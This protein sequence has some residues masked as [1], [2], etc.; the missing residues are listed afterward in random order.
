MVSASTRAQTSKNVVPNGS[1]RFRTDNASGTHRIV[2]K[3]CFKT[4]LDEYTGLVI[5]ERPNIEKRSTK[6][7]AWRQELSGTTN[8]VV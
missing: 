3:G 8:I 4:T 6:S 1:G 5:D 2:P 7:V